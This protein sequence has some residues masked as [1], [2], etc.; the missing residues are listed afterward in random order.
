MEKN[1]FT[2][3][4]KYLH[5]QYKK[6]LFIRHF[7]SGINS[8]QV[9]AYVSMIC[10][11]IMISLPAHAQQDNAARLQ[12][13][14]DATKIDADT[15]G[16]IHGG[17]IGLDIGQ[18]AFV[19]PKLGSGENRF[20][21]G[22]AINYFAH[23][24]HK[25]YNWANS[26]SLNMALEKL[27]SGAIRS[28]S[29][30]K[31]P[32]QKSIDELRIN[33]KF[34]YS[35]SE[36]SNFHY[37]V[38]FSFLSQFTPTYISKVD[39]GN[40]LKDIE[41]LETDLGAKL[42]SPATIVL[43]IGIDY[44]PRPEWSIYLSP[45]SYKGLIVAD[46][47]IAALGIHG[48]PWNS[49]TDYENTHHQMGGLLKIGYAGSLVPKRINYSTTLGLYSNYLKKPKNIDVDWVNELA[50][51]IYKGLQLSVLVNLFYDDDVKVQITDNDAVGG[52]KR[53]AEGKPIL[54]KRVSITEQMLLKYIH[55]F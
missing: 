45:L 51:T 18:L 35:I 49:E 14:K 32:F 38:D 8:R 10:I 12:E 26:F 43:G 39:G 52:I 1:Y 28:N 5:F 11:G 54:G 46:D 30:E 20:G 6:W 42:F 50:F 9:F 44:K 48:N 27:G 31:M 24:R 36:N 55:V 19:N 41:V 47:E 2:W 21:L 4:F 7:A 33:S 17:G 40:Y 3:T 37:A 53:D 23:L 13:L 25:R 29:D 15:T 22:G 16:W 34:G